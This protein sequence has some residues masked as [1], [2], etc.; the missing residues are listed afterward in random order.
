MSC[1]SSW[2]TCSAV[3]HSPTSVHSDFPAA[4]LHF[5]F[6][7]S[8]LFLFALEV[9]F[10]CPSLLCLSA[11]QMPPAFSLFTQHTHAHCL[12]LQPSDTSRAAPPLPRG[13]ESGQEG[14]IAIVSQLTI[15]TVS[16]IYFP[17]SQ[18][19]APDSKPLA[20][21]QG[22]LLPAGKFGSYQG[23]S[24]PWTLQAAPVSA[25]LQRA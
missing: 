25:A 20:P 4:G 11:G 17:R 12:E 18:E 8:I 19:D 15:V 3:S 16:S 2:G 10:S 23:F 5:S 22:L 13:R 1:C 21:H 24:S 7:P 14:S 6:P 9:T